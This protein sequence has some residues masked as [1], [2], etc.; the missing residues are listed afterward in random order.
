MFDAIFQQ[1]PTLFTEI[2]NDEALLTF[3]KYYPTIIRNIRIDEKMRFDVLDM[4]GNEL[5]QEQ[6]Y[7]IPVRK[8]LNGDPIRIMDLVNYVHPYNDMS[9]QNGLYNRSILGSLNRD[10]MSAYPHNNS[11][12]VIKFQQ[13]NIIVVETPYNRHINLMNM[14]FFIDVHYACTL[15]E[16]PDQ[17]FIRYFM[18]FAIEMTK[19]V[20][21]DMFK[22]SRDSHVFAGIEVNSFISEFS[23]AESKVNDWEDRFKRDWDT[24][25]ERFTDLTTLISY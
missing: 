18:S 12:I 7:Q 14:P 5:K 25:P 9:Q 2:L 20:I 1:E 10:V 13:P 24:N 4:S 11:Q 19:Q 23:D 15:E 16:I 22:T 8:N 6:Y 17:Y 21:Y 3:S